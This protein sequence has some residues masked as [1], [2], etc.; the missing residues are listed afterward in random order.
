MLNALLDRWPLAAALASAAMLATAHA[1]E[2]LGGY[3]PC[4]LCLRQREV[5]WA[6]LALGVAA[7]LLTR[8]P[9]GA[10]FRAAAGWA[11][12][13][14]FLAGAGVAAYHA[15][16]EWKLWP[17][18]AACAPS[19][20][21]D[22]GA[23]DAFLKGGQVRAISCTEAPWVFLGLSMAGWNALVSLGLAGLSALAALHGRRRG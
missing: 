14:L 3:A 18:P 5:Y 7:T 19:G 22:A 10:R 12:A 13:L 9:A 11:L 21:V 1:F 17:G 20:G 6:A 8:L 15:G 23:L 2:R 4:L 16:A